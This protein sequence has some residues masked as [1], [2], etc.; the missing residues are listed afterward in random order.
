MNE[1]LK[2]LGDKFVE[3]QNLFLEMS[4]L[5]S[6]IEMENDKENNA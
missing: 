3:M 6:K 1:L 2:E 4:I 5:I